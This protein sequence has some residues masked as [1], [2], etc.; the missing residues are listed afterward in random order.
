MVAILE[1]TKH[2]TDFHQIVDF[3]K[4]FYIRYALTIRPTIYVSHIRQFWSTTRVE[5]MDGETKILAQTIVA[6][7]TTKAEYVAAAS[8]CGQVL[9]IQ[10]QLLDYRDPVLNICLNFLHG[11][12]SEQRTHEFMH[13]YLASAS[14]T[15]ELFASIL[16]PQGKGS[17]HS[18]EPRH[19]PSDQDEPIHHEPITQSP[20]HAQITSHEPMPQS[21][22]QTTSSEPTIPS[23]SHSV[24]T[25]PRRITKGSIR[26]SQSKIPSPGADETVFLTGDVRGEDFPN[27]TSLDVGQ[28]RENIAKTSAMPHEALL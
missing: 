27:D 2:I 18:F 6:T 5:T 14:V 9:L 8:G 12:D 11:S 13:I 19:T 16:V 26:I 22:E 15:I 4:A 17:E 1:K 23:Q 7:S 20:Q 25:T 3:L 24:I 10:N 28:D 21:H